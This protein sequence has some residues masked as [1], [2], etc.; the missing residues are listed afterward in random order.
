M[1]APLVPSPLDYVGA[2]PFAFY[3]PLDHPDPN[4]WILGSGS[5]AEIEVVNAHTG[6]GIW[7]PRQHIGAVSETA[8]AFLIVGLTQPLNCRGASAEPRVKRVIEMPAATGHRIGQPATRHAGPAS[9]V[10]IR[11]ENRSDSAMSRAM[12]S[13][14]T[15]AIV[16]ALVTALVTAVIKF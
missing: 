9:V 5:R 1:S 7:I 2:R 12:L 15:G 16:I 13:A 4:E 11:L 14:F 3:P 8:D 6:R 10:A